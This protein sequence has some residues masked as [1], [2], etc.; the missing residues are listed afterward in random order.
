MCIFRKGHWKLN[1]QNGKTQLG[2]IQVT[3]INI[4]K[5]M[6]PKMKNLDD[7]TKM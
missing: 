4:N 5:G 1:L 7:L 2:Y 3:H 6:Y